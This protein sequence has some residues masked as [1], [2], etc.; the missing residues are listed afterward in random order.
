MLFFLFFFLI[1]VH[2]TCNYFLNTLCNVR[3]RNANG[4]SIRGSFFC[5]ITITHRT[6]HIDM[7][8]I[9]Y[10]ERN[11]ALCFPLPPFF[12]CSSPSA[13]FG[14]RR[15]YACV[16]VHVSLCASYCGYYIA[17]NG[18]SQCNLQTCTLP[19]RPL[20]FASVPPL[21]ST[22]LLSCLIF[23]HQ[24]RCIFGRDRGKEPFDETLSF[25]FDVH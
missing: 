21:C 7:V 14:G 22:P 19:L 13:T 4:C 16:H 23:K 9:G 24:S 18:T 11:Q 3:Y 6:K 20:L 8:I 1:N 17:I 2:P 5:L 25:E 10:N 15:W 12:P